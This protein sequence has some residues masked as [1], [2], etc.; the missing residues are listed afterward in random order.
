M[1]EGFEFKLGDHIIDKVDPLGV[2]IVTGRFFDVDTQ[3]RRYH[4]TASG[5]P[6]SH[7]TVHARVVEKYYIHAI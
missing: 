6:S 3:D 1:T 7:R 5:N 4:L 2:W